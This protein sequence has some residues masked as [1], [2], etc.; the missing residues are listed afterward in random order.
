[1]IKRKG[2]SR[3][4]V[5]DVRFDPSLGAEMRKVRPA[6]VISEDS[7]GRLPLRIVVPITDWKAEYA[8][9]PWF[10][11]DATGSAAVKLSTRESSGALILRI[12]ANSSYCS[13]TW[14]SSFS[15]DGPSAGQTLA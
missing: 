1:M 15:I 7:I 10:V 8:G 12:G 14:A 5:W 13:S 3:G 2:P 11:Y 6:V 9:Y 4:Q